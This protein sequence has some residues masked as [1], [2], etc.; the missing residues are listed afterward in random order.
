MDCNYH[1][2][3]EVPGLKAS[4]EQLARIYHRYHFAR[5]YAVAKD[6]LEVACG[7]GMGLGYLSRVARLVVGGDIDRRNV[8]LARGIYR[9]SAVVVREMDAHELPYD[10]PSFDLILLFEAIYYLHDP[11]S[12]VRAAARALR[13]GGVLIIC[14]V[15]RDWGDFHPSPYTHTYFSVPDLYRLLE[16][17]FEEIGLYGAFPVESSGAGSSLFSFIKRMA[18]H[19]ELIPGSLAARANLKRIFMGPLQPLPKQVVEG[20]APYEAPTVIDSVRVTA[21][22][23]ILYAVAKKGGD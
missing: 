10:Q 13:G 17:V 8:E 23:K 5:E 12:F 20:I 7:S 9:D 14:T 15:N 16:P 2:I 21:D 19:Y 6:V 1:A 3:T 11:A 18:V 4:R 22:Y